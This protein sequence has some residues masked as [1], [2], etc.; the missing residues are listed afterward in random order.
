MDA[1]EPPAAER[2]PSGPIERAKARWGRIPG[3]VRGGL[4]A[5]LGTGFF[6]TMLA[7][8]KAAGATLH[9]TEILLFRQLFMIVLAM[10]VLVRGFPEALITARPGFQLLRVT[11]AIGAMLFSFTA[12]IHL[13]LADTITISFARTFFISIFAILILGEV[14]GLR[15][16][17]AIVVGFAGV[18]IV[19][20][21]EGVGSFNI[22]G[23]MAI[24]GA[25][26]A[27]LVMVIIRVLSRTDRTV[28]IL[29]YQAIGIGL[30]MIPP[31]IWFWKTP[32]LYELMLLM[33]IGGVSVLSQ[34]CSIHAFRAGEASAIAPLDYVRLVYAIL[35]GYFVFAETPTMQVLVGAAVI[36]GAS[37]YALERERR[38]ERKRQPVQDKVTPGA[39]LGGGL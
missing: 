13:P 21:P 23:L 20:Q 28:T 25:A 10:P 26:C 39:G 8:I 18:L 15:R 33:G 24:A 37:L 12:V 11:A 4:W 35:I 9:V 30:V 5:L 1:P 27:G 22:Y 14:V 29:A 31:A 34:L 6:A 38:A 17:G 19:A 2:R 7:L 36:V 32:S 16:W 3:N